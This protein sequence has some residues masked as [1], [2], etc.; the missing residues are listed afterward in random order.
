LIP[1]K[2]LPLLMPFNG[3]VPDPILKALDPP[4]RFLV[5]LG[6]DRTDYSRPT[7]AKLIPDADP[8]G[9][10]DVQT[11]PISDHLSAAEVAGPKGADVP[12]DDT[13]GVADSPRMARLD[14]PAAKSPPKPQEQKH[15]SS[16]DVA[17]RTNGDP[18]RPIISAVKS[19]APRH[20]RAAKPETPS[21]PTPG[22]AD[23]VRSITTA[24]KSFA[25]RHARADKPESSS[26]PSA[27]KTTSDQN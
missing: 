25:P 23:P 26:Q 6:Y 10:T 21:H 27:D 8:N 4:L 17:S 2:E 3:I 13:E 16:L 20:A 12:A 22:V 7:P 19:F 11:Q 9:L 1:T 24:V 14:S 15:A 18:V 5:E